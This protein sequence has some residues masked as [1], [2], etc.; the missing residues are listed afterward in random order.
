MQGYL[1]TGRRANVV[2][3]CLVLTFIFELRLLV[4]RL[5]QSQRR[6]NMPPVFWAGKLTK[7]M[8]LLVNL[9]QRD[10]LD[11]WKCQGHRCHERRS[12]NESSSID[13]SNF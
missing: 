4:H 13:F 11:Q 9:K 1:A 8:M 10:G 3:G 6:E 2:C 5:L 7:S 12:F